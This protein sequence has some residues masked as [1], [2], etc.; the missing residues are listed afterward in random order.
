MIYWTVIDDMDDR[1]YFLLIYPQKTALERPD[2]GNG[3]W[4]EAKGRLTF[5]L[6]GEEYTAFR[7][8][9][10]LVAARCAD[11]IEVFARYEGHMCEPRAWRA[12]RPPEKTSGAAARTL[13]HGGKWRWQ[14]KNAFVF[15]EDGRLETPW[16]KGVWGMVPE[17]SA[18]DFVFARF[19]NI[20]HLLR[21][22]S[23]NRMESTR[24]DDGDKVV[25]TR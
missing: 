9:R 3:T 19:A 20:D 8:G 4:A 22:V 7:R 17:R 21:V 2:P 15:H 18:A 23:N 16:H 11:G 14:G 13:A 10:A 6:F 25:V 1:L 24:C 5:Q 12:L